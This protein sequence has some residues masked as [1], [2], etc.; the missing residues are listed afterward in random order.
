M[1]NMTYHFLFRIFVI[2]FKLTLLSKNFCILNVNKTKCVL[3]LLFFYF[4]RFV[5]FKKFVV[6]KYFFVILKHK[7]LQL[8]NFYL[9]FYETTLYYINLCYK[10]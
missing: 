3:F 4:K 6:Q 7:L 2:L 8:H 10:S 1:R 9:H 5:Y